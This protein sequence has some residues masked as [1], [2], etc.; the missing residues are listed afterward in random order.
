MLWKKMRKNLSCKFYFISNLFR[1]KSLTGCLNLPKSLIW[2]WRFVAKWNTAPGDFPGNFGIWK[3]LKELF[4]RTSHDGSFICYYKLQS[5]KCLKGCLNVDLLV[6]STINV[7]LG[8]LML[9]Y[10]MEVV[11]CIS[12]LRYHCFVR[13]T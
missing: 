13:I 7:L 12:I 6:H 9:T 8:I 11:L 1:W 3:I 2:N 5:V 4:R 10:S